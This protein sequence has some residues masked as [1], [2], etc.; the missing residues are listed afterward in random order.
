MNAAKFEDICTRAK[1][2]PREKVHTPEGAILVGERYSK[3]S[4]NYP[5]GHYEVLWA[6]ERDGCDIG[7]MLEIPFGNTTPE[8]RER[9]AVKA[10]QQ[11]IKDSV[12][13]GRY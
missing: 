6:I 9:A 8:S 3:A 5:L 10:A 13:S 7:Q 1:F 4:D 2:T 11:F 12:D